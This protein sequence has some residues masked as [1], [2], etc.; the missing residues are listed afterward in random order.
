M[1]SK[2]ERKFLYF[3]EET[4]EAR[5]PKFSPFPRRGLTRYLKA[6]YG[7][8]LQNLVLFITMWKYVITIVAVYI[9]VTSP[10]AMFAI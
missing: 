6:S 5:L 3:H 9:V 4:T 2:P 1:T 8:A 7:V 10:V